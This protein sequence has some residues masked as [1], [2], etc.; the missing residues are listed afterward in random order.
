MMSF[1]VGLILPVVSAILFG[2]M[3]YGCWPWEWQK[4]WYHTKRMRQ[5]NRE[6]AAFSKQNPNYDGTQ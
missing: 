1:W 3:A 5:L 4:T 6:F 2:R